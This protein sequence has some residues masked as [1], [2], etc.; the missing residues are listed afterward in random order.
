VLTFSSVCE[1]LVCCYFA[2]STQFFETIIFQGSVVKSERSPLA[3][4]S[5][6]TDGYT[7]DGVY[8]A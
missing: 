8:I 1:R 5:E 6:A 3:A 7:A 2:S 4:E